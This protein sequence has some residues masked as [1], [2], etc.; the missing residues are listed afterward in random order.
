MKVLLVP[1]E[2]LTAF[3][4]N[5]RT[6]SID[7]LE[8]IEESMKEYG[9]VEPIIAYQDDKKLMIVVG[10]QRLDAAIERGLKKVPV[11]IY[12]FK[13]LKHAVG[14]N[15]ASNK[16]AELSN[17]DIPKLKDNLEFLDDGQFNL[18]ATG[19]KEIEIEELQTWTP[20]QETEKSHAG[21]KK[22]RTITCPECGHE[23]EE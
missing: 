18:E 20:P 12:P 2:K 4:G 15:I 14:Y 17:W 3:E 10:H 8:R 5:P 9:F 22:K 6:I 11:I 19:F 1:I 13:D 16:T 21:E 7:G 23:W